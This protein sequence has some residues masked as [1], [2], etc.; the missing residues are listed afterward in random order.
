MKNPLSYQMSEYDCGPTAVLNALMYLFDR[1]VIMPDL[2]KNVYKY[3]LDRHDKTGIQGKHGTSNA[4]MCFLTDYLN[5]YSKQTGFTMSCECILGKEVYIKDNEKIND[6]INNNGVVVFKCISDVPHYVLMTDIKG[7]DVY[8]F[9]SYFRKRPFN[10]DGIEIINDPFKA[11]R[12][13][14]QYVL[15]NEGK[16]DYNLGDIEDRIAV[17]IH[18]TSCTKKIRRK[19]KWAM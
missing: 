12:I 5:H 16:S 4:S 7:E 2:I 13:V 3:T 1:E 19:P 14:K 15:D 17:L 10:L 6:C 8:L 11:N 18:N 9:D